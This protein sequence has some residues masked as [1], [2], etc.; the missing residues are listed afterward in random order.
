[1]S[2]MPPE[3]ADAAE[4]LQAAREHLAVAGN[5]SDPARIR[6]FCAQRAVELAVKAAL[7]HLG[8]DFPRLHALDELMALVPGGV[9]DDVSQADALTPY[10]VQ[11]IYPD[12]YTGL[13]D[14]HASEAVDLARVAVEWAASI[15]A[16]DPG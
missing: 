12:T 10:A 6:C 8:V 4:W 16:H 14:D 15:V 7:I 3:P 13:G 2:C 1:M 5:V 9:P 11:E